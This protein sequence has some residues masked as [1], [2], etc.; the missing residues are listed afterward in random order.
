[1]KYLMMMPSWR[2]TAKKFWIWRSSWRKYVINSNKSIL[3]TD[4]YLE[5]TCFK[6]KAVKLGGVGEL[7][8]VISATFIERT[9]IE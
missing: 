3:S 8:K 9:E 6:P 2:D 4:N 1:M 5:T 7:F